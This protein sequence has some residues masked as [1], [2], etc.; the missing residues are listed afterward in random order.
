MVGAGAGR[1]A[2]GGRGKALM[3]GGTEGP[4]RDRRVVGGCGGEEGRVGGSWW[5]R[6]Q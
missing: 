2:R 5:S 3:R 4:T 6:G 1:K